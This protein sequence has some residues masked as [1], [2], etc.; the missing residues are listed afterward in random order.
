MACNPK[1]RRKIV[2]MRALSSVP[3]K[4]DSTTATGWVVITPLGREAGMGLDFIEVPMLEEIVEL[5]IKEAAQLVQMYAESAF[6][7]PQLGHIFE[8][9]IRSHFR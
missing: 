1:K 2:V 7:A 3:V 4:E 5:S 8:A 6:L 9:K